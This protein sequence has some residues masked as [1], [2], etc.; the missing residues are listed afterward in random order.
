MK[1]KTDRK[2]RHETDNNL[3]EPKRGTRLIQAVVGIPWEP[4]WDPMGTSL[5]PK[6]PN[7]YHF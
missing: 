1:E 5:G 4:P 2:D 6:G 7:L 3:D